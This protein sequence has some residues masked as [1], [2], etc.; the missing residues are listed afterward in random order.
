MHIEWNMKQNRKELFKT[1]L[2]INQ[3]K[4]TI[5]KEIRWSNVW[6]IWMSSWPSHQNTPKAPPEWQLNQSIVEKGTDALV[7]LSGDHRIIKTMA[8][9][10]SHRRKGSNFTD[11]KTGCNCSYWFLLWRAEH[12]IDSSSCARS[13]S[14]HMSLSLSFSLLFL[15]SCLFFLYWCNL[16]F[17]PCESHFALRQNSYK[18]KKPN[19]INPL[20]G[21]NFTSLKCSTLL[22]SVAKSQSINYDC[23]K[24]R[25]KTTNWNFE[26]V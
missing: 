5:G 12:K 26:L 9:S 23:F 10:L 6:V 21:T 19:T 1:Y 17:A 24:K 2:Q 14:R 13:K 4:L 15:P 3:Y 25:I 16:W 22:T 11:E 8:K 18:V 7:N 20:Q